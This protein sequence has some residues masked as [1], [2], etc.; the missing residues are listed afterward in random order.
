MRPEAADSHQG[1]ERDRTSDRPDR[2]THPMP[3]VA[4][5]LPCREASIDCRRCA[6]ADA[7][8]EGEGPVVGVEH[9]LLGLARIGPD[10]HHAAV[11]E[12]NMGDLHGH[13]HAVD[14]DDLVAPIELVGLARREE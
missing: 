9:H 2:F 4:N 6:R 13:C 3:P 10:E 8:K 7:T 14:Q 12:P 1:Q 11:A 5:I